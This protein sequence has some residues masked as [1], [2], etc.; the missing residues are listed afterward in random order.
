GDGL[1]DEIPATYNRTF[2]ATAVYTR[3]LTYKFVTEDGEVILEKTDE[4][5][6]LILPPFR[7]LENDPIYRYNVTYVGYE[8]GMLLT[9]NFEFVVKAE[10]DSVKEYSYSFV[11]DGQVVHSGSLEHGAVIT[12]PEDPTKAAEEH[13]T[14]VFAG[15]DGYT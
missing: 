6:A 11:V 12:L 2:G 8:A 7:Y 1:A 4:Y 10:V 14:F 3:Q 5:N 9:E 13:A 15:W